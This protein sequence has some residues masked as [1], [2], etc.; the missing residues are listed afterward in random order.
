LGTWGFHGENRTVNN[1]GREI[2]NTWD[3]AIYTRERYGDFGYSF[4]IADGTYDVTLH[5]CEMYRT[6]PGQRIFDVLIEGQIVLDDLDIFSEVGANA[7]LKK[8]FAGVVVRDGQL[9][10]DFTQ[11]VENPEINGIELNASAGPVPTQTPSPSPSPSPTTAPT[12][13]TPP[14]PTPTPT[15]PPT[16]TPAPTTPPAPTPTPTPAPTPGATMRV[17]TVDVRIASLWLGW[18]TWGEAGITV[19]DAAGMPVPGATVAGH[20]EIA[21][22]DSDSG[23]T[24]SQGTFSCRSNSLRFPRTGTTFV[25]VVDQISKPG[26]FYDEGSS[27][28]TASAVVR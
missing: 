20:W 17:T 5:F 7:A 26:W 18:R 6:G 25:F 13:T 22:N 21:T 4:D 24:T 14:A 3:D 12:P 28:T 16:P 23:F 9:N 8:S 11:Q 15:V 2:S 19:V 27:K 10:I 1:D